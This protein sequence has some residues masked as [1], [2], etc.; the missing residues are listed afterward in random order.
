G[1]IPRGWSAVADPTRATLLPARAVEPVEILVE[2]GAE[3][4]GEDR[5][6]VAGGLGDAPVL[7][8][9][10]LVQ[11]LADEGQGRVLRLAAAAAAG[12]PGAA[13]ATSLGVDP[14]GLEQQL[15]RLGLG[16]DRGGAGL[17]RVEDG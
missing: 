3:L 12:G 2:P 1:A 10:A 17:G 11:A 4:L 16:R 9:L 6:G 13:P 7:A 14:L 5:A 15:D 8:D